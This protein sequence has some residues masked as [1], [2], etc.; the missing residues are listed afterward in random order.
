MSGQ[1]A[2]YFNVEVGGIS[3]PL[4]NAHERKYLR[5]INTKRRAMRLGCEFQH[6]VELGRT[7]ATS[8]PTALLLSSDFQGPTVV[9]LYKQTQF[10]DN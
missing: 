10:L 1:N 3:R 6:I 8:R 4:L 2:H 9:S 5:E 7:E